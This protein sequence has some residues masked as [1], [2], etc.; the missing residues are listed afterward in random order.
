MQLSQ[1]EESIVKDILMSTTV[2]VYAF[3]SRVRGTARQDSDLDL[4]L[5][6]PRGQVPLEEMARLREL[7]EASSLPFVVDIVDYQNLSEPFKKA[8]DRD[9]LKLR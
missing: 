8:I 7:F 3:G 9:G 1:R 5:R 6:S 4:C 2:D